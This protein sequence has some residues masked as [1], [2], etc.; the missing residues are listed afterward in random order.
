MGNKVI[1][2]SID[3][4]ISAD[5]PILKRLPNM[6]NIM[7]A[8]SW[9]TD[10][11]CVYPTLTYP[12]HAT[13]ATGVYPCRH[14]IYNNEILDMN[15]KKAD[16]YWW[17]KDIRTDTVIDA[18]KRA[19]LTTG[20]V[21][22]PV[23][24]DAGADYGIGEIWAPSGQEDPT[25]Y[26]DRANS[27]GAKEIFE[28]NKDKLDWLR[29]PEFDNF[30]AACA[31]D[32]IREFQPDLLLVH[33]SYV[34]HQRHNHGVDMADIE[35]PLAFV[36]EK[37]GEI[38]E[39]AVSAGVFED[40][41]FV[42]V[43]DHGQINCHAVFHLN[44]VL[45]DR[46]YIDAEENG[47][48]KDYRIYCHSCAYSAQIYVQN[49]PLDEAKRVLEEIREEY[50]GC[51]EAIYTREQ[52]KERFHTDGPFSFMVEGVTGV[53]FGKTVKAEK[54]IQTATDNSDYRWSNSTHGHDPGKGDKPPMIAAGPWVRPGV[55]I[56]GGRLVDEAP[57]VMALL[58]VPMEDV[59][60]KVLDDLLMKERRE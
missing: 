2:I 27:P 42:L 35:R 49:M 19:G 51:M 8:A 22:W 52:V 24:G 28:R 38:M 3:S 60:G 33:F 45:W 40:T 56:H 14:G 37:I 53:T 32:V 50:P 20:C 39:A 23:L 4:L 12:C 29:T 11:E 10:M 7:E 34:D 41:N 57:T 30:A 5:L 55:V 47:W 21:A 15:A 13:I 25:P 16:W 54:V 9:V 58:G 18:A 26:F 31:S 46:G 48:V 36:D 6:G 17:R 44:K 59:D 43:G 1:L